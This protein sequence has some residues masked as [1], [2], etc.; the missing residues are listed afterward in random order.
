MGETELNSGKL[1]PTVGTKATIRCQEMNRRKDRHDHRK[2]APLDRRDIYRSI[3]G[4]GTLGQ[5]V[6]VLL[7]GLCGLE[8]IPVG[9]YELVPHD[10]H[11]APA[12]PAG[13]G[14]TGVLRV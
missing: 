13:I 4:A 1:F 9:F 5:P 8:F 7:Y 12:R 11:L 14:K 3:P 10:D 2:N 6:L